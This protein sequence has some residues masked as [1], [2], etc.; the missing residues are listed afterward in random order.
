MFWAPP[1]LWRAELEPDYG[2]HALA[3]GLQSDLRFEGETGVGARRVQSYLLRRYDW[4]AD[5]ILT[6]ILI[7]RWTSGRL[8][9]RSGVDSGGA[10]ECIGIWWIVAST[11]PNYISTHS[12]WPTDSNDELGIWWFCC[13]MLRI[14]FAFLHLE[15]R[16]NGHPWHQ[17][18]DIWVFIRCWKVTGAERM[19]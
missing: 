15:P 18:Y 5:G 8:S 12:L 1:V 4:S 17:S 7:R 16:R 6:S 3:M 10:A 2:F 9:D 13:M 19:S 11:R 14:Y